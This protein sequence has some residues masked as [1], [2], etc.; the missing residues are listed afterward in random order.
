MAEMAEVCL[1]IDIPNLAHN[2][3]TFP[4][5]GPASGIAEVFV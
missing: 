5:P 1:H 2:Q 3:G 4:Y